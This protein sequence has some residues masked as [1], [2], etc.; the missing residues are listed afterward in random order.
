VN[1]NEILHHHGYLGDIHRVPTHGVRMQKEIYDMLEFVLLR[2]GRL[3]FYPQTTREFI[4]ID[5]VVNINKAEERLT[6]LLSS[7]SVSIDQ[8]DDGV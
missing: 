5:N 4:V 2:S 6:Q 1:R 8:N 3:I 7:V